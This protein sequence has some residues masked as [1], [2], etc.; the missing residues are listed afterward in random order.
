MEV[1]TNWKNS[2]HVV[3]GYEGLDGKT[4]E[5]N[6]VVTEVL[7]DSI[8]KINAKAYIESQDDVFET[9]F[10]YHKTRGFTELTFTHD[11]VHFATIHL[12]DI[13]QQD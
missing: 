11:S 2:I 10:T 6:Y 5:S 1:N 8:F 13:Y 3:H 7:G 4:V 12:I 9:N